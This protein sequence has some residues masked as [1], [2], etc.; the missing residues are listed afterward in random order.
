MEFCLAIE[1]RQ[2]E[3][4]SSVALLCYAM[5]RGMFCQLGLHQSVWKDNVFLDWIYL[6]R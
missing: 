6:P 2:V 4:C 1:C 5:Q 3:A